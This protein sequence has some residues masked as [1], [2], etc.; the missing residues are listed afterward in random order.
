[1]PS[2]V[3]GASWVGAACDEALRD[4]SLVSIGTFV[5]VG[6]LVWTGAL[7]SSSGAAA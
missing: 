6:A 5:G 1:V 2:P 7:V 3:G 4:G